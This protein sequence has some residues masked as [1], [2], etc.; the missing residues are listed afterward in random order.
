MQEEEAKKDNVIHLDYNIKDDQ[1]RIALVNKIIENTPPEKLTQTYLEKLSDYIVFN[2]TLAEND[3]RILTPNRIAHIKRRETS[4]EGLIEKLDAGHNNADNKKAGEDIIY[5]MITNDKNKI[6]DPKKK[7]TEE[8]VREIPGL[9]EFSSEL[10]RMEEVY[11]NEPH[12]KKRS[13]YLKT[14]IEMRGDRYVFKTSYKPSMTSSPKRGATH[15][16]FEIYENIE[17]DPVTKEPIIKSAN[18]TLLD[19]KHVSA[20]LDNYADLMQSIEGKVKNDLYYLMKELESLIDQTF[21]ENNPIYYDLVQY[22]IQKKTNLQIQELLIKNHQTKYSIEYISSLWKNKIPKMLAE[23]AKENYILWYYKMNP[24]NAI[25]KK[26]SR[27]GQIKLAH[28][29]FFSKNKT[30]KDGFYS[31]CKECRN[32]KN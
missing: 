24:S 7:I 31:I 16:S 4:F 13:S 6:L 2:Q 3:R 10:E 32:K 29:R 5:G 19:Q 8:E 1:E 17:M 15:H 22:K 27:C 9:S 18:I 11:K 14:V 28:N 26:C 12:G 23:K 21:K 25:W 20:I 30:S